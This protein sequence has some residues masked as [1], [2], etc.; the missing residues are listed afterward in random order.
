MGMRLQQER[1]E[2]LGRLAQA[3]LDVPG[4]FEEVM[5]LL[6]RT[7]PFDA[8][9]WHTL[10]P[11]TLLETSHLTLNLPVENPVA[12]EIEYLE[13]DYNQFATLARSRA[14]SG[15]LSEATGGRPERS[16]RYRELIRPF[17]LEGELRAAL[18]AGGTAWG[19]VGLLRDGGD[20]RPD[21]VSFL[22]AASEPLGESIRRALLVQAMAA[23]DA[24]PG[25]G[26]VLL[27]EEQRL[28]AMTPPAERLLCELVDVPISGLGDALP[29]V[30]HAVATRAHLA[31]RAGPPAQAR[32]RTRAGRWLLLHG[33]LL[34]GARGP[35]TAVIVE[36]AS[37]AGIA[38][39]LELAYGLT[40][41]ESAVVGLLLRGLSTKEIAAE[42]YI[43]PYT[44]QEH[45]IAIFEKVGVRSRRELVGRVFSQQYES[46][47][48]AGHGPGPMGWFQQPA[49]T[50]GVDGE[51]RA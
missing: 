39:V 45:C 50:R 13:D 48:L 33:S 18:V 2:A 5:P 35:R 1:L 3:G 49:G 6:K 21:E 30:V 19:A 28:E 8:A 32:V 12:T 9:C 46:R 7:V 26:L 4:L 11:A 47:R 43:S 37:A 38:P 31:E 17:G 29:Y 34:Q 10:D 23:D 24:A 42:L 25:P 44:V 15:I 40:A 36:E 14:R 16:R 22:R 41:R 20:F 27:D 51:V